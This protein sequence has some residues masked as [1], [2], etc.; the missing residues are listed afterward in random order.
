MGEVYRARD[1]RLDRIVAVKVLL[2]ERV[3]REESK[4]RFIQEAKA[5]SALNHPN[6]IAIY[7]IGVENGV[8]YIAM[9]FVS[10]KTLDQLI[11][12]NGMRL[13]EVLRHAVEAADAL[14]KAHAAGIVHRDLKP[15]NIMVSTDGLVKVLDFGLAKLAKPSEDRE[16]PTRTIDARTS[17]GTIMGTAAYMSP[18]QAEGQEAGPRSD[19]FSF[20]ALL[21]EMVSGQRAFRGDTLLSTLS[22]VLRDDPKPITEVRE[23]SPSELRRIIARCLRKDPAQRFQH[24]DDLKVALEELKGELE[25]GKPAEPVIP[26]S[27]RR[28]TSAVLIAAAAL[29]TAAGGMAWFLN[30]TTP[31][32]AGGLVLTRMTSDSGLTTTPAISP[33]G[34]LLA[35]ASDRSGEG[36]LDIWV[37]QVA[38]G[39]PI[40][41]TRNSADDRQ[42]SFS[43]DGSK[44]A[45]RSER[46]GGGIYVISALGGEDRLVARSGMYPHFSPDGNRIAYSVGAPLRSS[47][48]YIVNATGGQASEWK[49]QIPWAAVP[50]W[51]P[52]GSHI[53]FLGSTDPSGNFNTI[54][55]WVAPAE[56]GTAIGTGAGSAFARRG[57][58][59]PSAPGSW[60]GDRILFSASLGDSANL[61]QAKI[62]LRT[63]Q[64]QDPPQRLTT[65]AAQES[66]PS[67][68]ADG[69]LAFST[70]V[71]E[72]NL[73]MLAIDTNRGKVLGTP[74]QLTTAGGGSMRPSLS[75]DG[76]KLV[77]VSNRS[78]NPDIWLRNLDNGSE[79]AITAT[80]WPES[81]PWL[82]GDGSKVAWTSLETSKPPIFVMTI[83]RGVPEKLCDDCGMPMQWTPDGSKVLYYWGQPIRYGSIDAITRQRADVIHHE[84][85]N[86]HRARFSPDGNWLAFHVPIVVEGGR[87][88]IF[89]APLRNG[90]ALGETDWIQV[91]DG[92]GIEAAPFWSPDGGLLY[93]LSQR[94][95]FQCLWAQPLDKAT[96]RPAGAPFNIAHFHGARHRVDEVGFGPGI[97][98]DKLVYTLS[99]ST[100]NVWMAKPEGGRPG[101]ARR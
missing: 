98:S 86:I 76:R 81:H 32:P 93:F 31:Q 74:Q 15:G 47:K 65:G 89:V 34:K 64:I 13:N 28:R 16:A 58:R 21:Y 80:P 23:D 99:E 62:S 60:T 97:S 67:I 95:G 14:A 40:R 45:F 37:Q 52:D 61:W 17:E 78:G 38:G 35:Y 5:A 39:Q 6:I 56:G 30:R 77:F 72:S 59:A 92:T 90:V 19:I 44:I 41:R 36:N 55:W 79:T 54:D 83:A 33:D 96:K 10:G 53:L 57:L 68:S 1:T 2:P 27:R 70:L 82:T 73:W 85:Y 71:S 63:W 42:P 9:E 51:S 88:P 24:M 69:S 100:G 101:E 26:P 75:Q 25:S 46:D 20:G 91:T 18:E 66:G 11:P 29:T 94:D 22:S 43:P 84:K 50:I 87:S 7:D 48:I 12:R 8:D 49:L 4:A 3:V